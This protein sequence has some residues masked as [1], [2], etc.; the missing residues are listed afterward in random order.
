MN[1]IKVTPDLQVSIHTFPKGN[2][3]EE[4]KAL[5][6]LIGCHTV[7]HVM[8]ELLYSEL[9][10]HCNPYEPDSLTASMLVDEDGLAK[11]LPLNPIGSYLYGTQLHGSPILGTIL[12]I[13]EELT[14][15][16]P[17]FCGL[18]DEAFEKLLPQ[19]KKMVQLAN[20]V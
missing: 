10:M 15:D 17:S 18:S 5:A 8:P 9:G 3:R 14:E 7:E 13:G 2:T 12:F 1:I 19:I 4:M 20:E 11:E 6:E 16:G